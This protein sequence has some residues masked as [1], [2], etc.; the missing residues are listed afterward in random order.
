MKTSP[1]K[2]VL[3]RLDPEVHEAMAGIAKAEK[4]SITAQVEMILE[5][6]LE[7][8]ADDPKLGQFVPKIEPVAV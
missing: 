7:K 6:Y 3:L 2:A 1:H 4:R 5:A 8:V